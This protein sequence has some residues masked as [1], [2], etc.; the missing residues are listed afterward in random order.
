MYF[1]CVKD[2]I[3]FDGVLPT[4]G[5]IYL[6]CICEGNKYQNG[7][8]QQ[9]CAHDVSFLRWGEGRCRRGEEV[10]D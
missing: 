3:Q 4:N 1:E 7:D 10:V 2:D 5:V 6:A 9:Q 8:N